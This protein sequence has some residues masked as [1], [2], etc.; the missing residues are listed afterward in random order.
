[1]HEYKPCVTERR[2]LSRFKGKHL[3]EKKM[4]GEKA[5]LRR[6]EASREVKR[7]QKEG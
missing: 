2:G 4:P 7:K 6:R 3:V 1:M 5:S